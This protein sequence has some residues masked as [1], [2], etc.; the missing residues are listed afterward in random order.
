[1][2]VIVKELKMKI[3][4]KDEKLVIK[5]EVVKKFWMDNNVKNVIVWKGIYK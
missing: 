3:R 5:Q 4:K 1:M 2:N